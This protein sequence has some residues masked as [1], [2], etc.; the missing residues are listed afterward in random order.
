MTIGINNNQII[1]NKNYKMKDIFM[2]N[3][4]KTKQMNNIDNKYNQNYVKKKLMKLYT[5]Y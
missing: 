4:T 5:P 3:I 1:I 2:N